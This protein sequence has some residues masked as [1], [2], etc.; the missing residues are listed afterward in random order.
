MLL[1]GYTNSKTKGHKSDPYNISITKLDYTY[2]VLIK[3][4]G[5]NIMVSAMAIVIIFTKEKENSTIE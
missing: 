2:L 1:Q 4:T 3:F 5:G